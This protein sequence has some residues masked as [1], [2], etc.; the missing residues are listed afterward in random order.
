MSSPVATLPAG[1]MSVWRTTE[2]TLLA[3]SPPAG[4]REFA[5]THVRVDTGDALLTIPHLRAALYQ[6]D[7]LL[8]AGGEVIVH[9]DASDRPKPGRRTGTQVQ[10][11]LATIFP[12]CYRQ[13][14]KRSNRLVFQKTAEG[15]NSGA[16]LRSVSVGFITDGKSTDIIER[17]LAVLADLRETLSVEVLL[18]GPVDKLERLM[19]DRDWVKLAGDYRHA[20]ARP[21]I[22][23][24]KGLIIDA[25]TGENLI[26]AHDRFLLDEIFWRRLIA[27]GNRFDFYNC[28]HCSLSDLP[29]ERRVSGDYG[30][31][32]SPIDGFGPVERSG[33]REYAEA[34]AHFYNNGGLF[35]GKRH[36]FLQNR[37]PRHLHWGD[38]EDVH[39]T[40]H[41]ELDGAVWLHDWSNRVFTTTRRMGYLPPVRPDQRLRRELR[42]LLHWMGFRLRHTTDEIN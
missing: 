15:R 37:W 4:L 8:S 39:F 16:A 10:H 1:P 18:A 36:W 19:G 38:L 41:C 28:R 11:A 27:F 33:S 7:V 31:H 25:A 32:F 13:T 24:K 34:N 12:D 35:I 21:P 14:D 26:L 40:R 9:S 3:S 6:L 5:G 22:N 17:N 2:L 29:S 20:D 42:R 23:R 30:F